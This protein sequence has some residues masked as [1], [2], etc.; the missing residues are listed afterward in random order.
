MAIKV[1]VIVAAP[2][3]ADAAAVIAWWHEDW[4]A[5]GDTAKGA[6]RR[7]RTAVARASGGH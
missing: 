4:S 7:I 1:H 5:I 6:A 3:G 2:S